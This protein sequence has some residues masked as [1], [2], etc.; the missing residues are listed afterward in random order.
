M[1]K[2]KL[3]TIIKTLSKTF[4]YAII[5]HYIMN[6]KIL[7]NLIL[8]FLSSCASGF[9]YDEELLP[10]VLKFQYNSEIYGGKYIEIENLKIVFKDT[11]WLSPNTIGVC[12]LGGIT[13]TIN[14]KPDFW[15][16]ASESEREALIFHELGHCILK[17]AH[18]KDRMSIM[19][20]E[21]IYDFYSHED[22]YLKEL[23][24]Y[25]KDGY[26]AIFFN[27]NKNKELLN[28]DNS[29]LDRLDID[30]DENCITKDLGGGVTV[31]GTQN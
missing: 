19:K 9:H 28:K 13:P 18:R 26:E 30:I 14:I 16:Y 2:I 6:F 21:L 22:Y 29:D 17:Q 11:T 4:L 15:E 5:I 12:F 1:N 20:P 8:I 10:Y 25:G 24:L 7:T 23:F 3:S 31:F 27:A